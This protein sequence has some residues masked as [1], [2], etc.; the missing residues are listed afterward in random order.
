MLLW[1]V[2]P[3]QNIEGKKTEANFNCHVCTNKCTI[4]YPKTLDVWKYTCISGNLHL[5]QNYS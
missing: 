5:K 3:Y 2:K 1:I 4:I